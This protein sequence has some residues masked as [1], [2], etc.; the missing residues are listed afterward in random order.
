MGR[1]WWLHGVAWTLLGTGCA[2]YYV[3][4]NH[5]ESPEARGAA[6]SEGKPTIGR[7]EGVLLHQGIDINA[8]PV[9]PAAAPGSAVTPAKEMQ[10]AP[11]NLAFGFS[12]SFGESWDV[13]VRIYPYAPML[14]RAKYQFL[15]PSEIR[16]SV[17]DFSASVA[18]AGGILLGSGVVFSLVDAAMPLGYRVEQNHLLVLTPFLSSASVSGMSVPA[19][20]GG[21]TSGAVSQYGVALGYQYHYLGM[22][23]RAEASMNGGSCGASVISGW[24]FGGMAGLAL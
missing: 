14:L 18:V 2:H 24:Y 4:S 1:F 10:K 9:Q 22:I 16:A 19:A 7:L 20:G 23:L 13:G 12:K 11:I 3:P 8:E 6:T 5:L 17:N 15:G 21:A